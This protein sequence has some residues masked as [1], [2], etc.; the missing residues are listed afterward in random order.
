[1]GLLTSYLRK[2]D[3][4]LIISVV[5]IVCFGL[6]AIYSTCVAREDF[7]NLT[8]QIIFF[9]VGF[10]LMILISFLDYRIFRN[11]SYLILSFYFICLVLLAGLH[12][13]APD[14]RGTRG[15]YKIGGLSL[16]PIEPTKI[17]LLILLAK[18]FSM[19]HVEMYKFR[20]IIFSGL[21]VFL[22]ALLIFIK[23]DLG[24]V[25]VLVLMWAGILSVSGI[26]LK[27]FLILFLIFILASGLAWQFLL[28]D[29][30]RDR[31]L[32]FVFPYDPL[33]GSWSQNQTK[34]AI[35]SGMI[36]GQGLGNGSQVQYG[37]L[38]EPH[39]DFIFSVI[40]EE[41]GIIGVIILFLLYLNV[42]WRI[43]KISIESQS[44]FAR[45]FCVGFVLML[46]IQFTVN[47]GMNIGVFPVV[48]IYLP[49]ISYGG[50]GLI[51]NFISLGIVQSIKSRR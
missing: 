30:Q 31:V 37:F 40:A 19:R 32:S 48:G 20:H 36:F 5:L 24:G 26:K 3:W 44:N 13:F 4:N 22:P 39:T 17:I 51:A 50:S 41:W 14:I 49:F 35:G 15:W 25:M 29:Y 23:P 46:I 10:F 11:N 12:F 6:L 45:L 16:D 9:A 47:I 8:K 18:Y 1:M 33:G 34:I 38:P 21:Y 28:K 42:V 27:H 2:L 7:S 43:L